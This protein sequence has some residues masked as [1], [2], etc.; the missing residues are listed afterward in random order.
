MIEIDELMKQR[1][2]VKFLVKLGKNSNKVIKILNIVY[3]DIAL[4]KATV[5]KWIKNFNEDCEDCKENVVLGR[6]STS[7]DNKNVKLVR[8]R[9]FFYRLMTI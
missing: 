9:V 2:N 5:S 1:V 6:P 3:G 4:K 7:C 8:R